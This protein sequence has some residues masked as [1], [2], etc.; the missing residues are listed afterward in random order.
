MCGNLAKL[1]SNYVDN[2]FWGNY[3]L[4]LCSHSFLNNYLKLKTLNF[5]LNFDICYRDVVTL[6]M[7]MNQNG[8]NGLP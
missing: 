4:N 5:E 2:Y 3:C 6:I 1:I 8:Q 7:N